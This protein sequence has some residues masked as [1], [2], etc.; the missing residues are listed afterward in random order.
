MLIFNVSY[1]NLSVHPPVNGFVQVL[2]HTS[3]NA[4]LSHFHNFCMG[5]TKFEALILLIHLK[6]VKISH[7]LLV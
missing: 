4:V 2:S 7:R 5:G 3:Q 6:K 1:C